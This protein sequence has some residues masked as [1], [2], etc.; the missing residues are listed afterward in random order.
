[1]ANA[2]PRSSRKLSAALCRPSALSPGAHDNSGCAG[3]CFATLRREPLKEEGKPFIV[4]VF[5][6]LIIVINKLL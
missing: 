5:F 2:E 6:S 3:H 1:V 4:H